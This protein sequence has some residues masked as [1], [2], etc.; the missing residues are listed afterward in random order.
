MGTAFTPEEQKLIRKD[1]KKAAR[2][3]LSTFGMR[4]TSVDQLVAEVGIS[5]GAFYKFYP[6]KEHLFFELMEDIHDELYTGAAKILNDKALPA[7]QRLENTIT[8]AYQILAT[9]D[10]LTFLTDEFPYVLRKLSPDILEKHRQDDSFNVNLLLNN[11]GIHLNYSPDFISN[12]ICT[13]VSISREKA[14]IGED[15][16]D[17]V[18]CFLIHTSCVKLLEGAIIDS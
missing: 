9:G 12:L 11:A 2:K 13:L 17:E 7:L 4:K 1:L 15:Y 6:T 14:L 16:Y 3:N 18:V 10:I 5:K 8:Y